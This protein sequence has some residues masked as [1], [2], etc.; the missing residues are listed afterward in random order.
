MSGAL[1]R[2]LLSAR[3]GP[4]SLLPMPLAPQSSGAAAPVED[5]QER[6]AVAPPRAAAPASQASRVR[7]P[8]GDR[9]PA[10]EVRAPST[11]SPPAASRHR[12]QPGDLSG[13]LEISD[14]AAHTVEPAAR[15]TPNGASQLGDAHAA[16]SHSEQE[17]NGLSQRDA[18]A[19]RVV[20][21]DFV[22]AVARAG[23][24]PLRDFAS[25][26]SGKPLPP[27]LAGVRSPLSRN[28]SDVSAERGRPEAP[29]DDLGGYAS[30]S[31]PTRVSA[32]ADAPHE[33]ERA[34]ARE[35][36]E[37]RAA[38][39]ER[40]SATAMAASHGGDIVQRGAAQPTRAPPPA[41]HVTIGRIDVQAAPAAQP[42]RPRAAPPQQP[43]LSLEEYLKGRGRRVP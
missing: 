35:R 1:D 41:V 36:S 21:P 19:A 31:V 12:P 18:S 7:Q 3:D 15:H 25:S 2:L 5:V 20:A 9:S 4:S 37:E 16:F 14:R 32:G 38:A 26:E 24:I 34:A 23:D 10:R 6:V 13:P 43:K 40:I 17:A 42:P 22:Q 39:R 33:R 28:A 8:G 30:E 11:A 29:H 27:E